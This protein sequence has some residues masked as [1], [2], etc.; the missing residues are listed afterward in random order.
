[1][2]YLVDVTTDGAETVP[3][4]NSGLNLLEIS[5]AA[6]VVETKEKVDSW[7]PKV[8][9]GFERIESAPGFELFSNGTDFVAA[10]DLR[11]SGSLSI[12][13]GDQLGPGGK[14]A[15]GGTSPEFERMS[16]AEAMAKSR[17][18]NSASKCVVN[19]SFFST[20]NDSK[21][22]V[23]F[24]MKVDGTVVTEGFAPLSKHAGKRMA[25]E[26]FEHGA[27]IT[28][29]R[30]DNIKALQNSGADDALVSLSPDVDIDN[31]K[32]ARTGRTF[33]GLD[34]KAANGL[35]T[36]ALIFVSPNSSQLHAELTLKRFG[37]QPVIMLDGGGSSQLRC[38]TRDYVG[39]SNRARNVPQ[40]ISI[41]SE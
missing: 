35:Y 1:M 31:R 21:A 36:R 12:V 18:L 5:A 23:A 27:R 19:G 8:A 34:H 38:G 20:Q 16:G 15:T 29:F 26:I 6:P 11:K 39:Q 14:S 40:F 4:E 30:N 25:L 24:P 41:E 17:S 9:E 10:V 33:L 3:H 2:R 22:Q 37:A 32:E 7:K 28:S 13:A